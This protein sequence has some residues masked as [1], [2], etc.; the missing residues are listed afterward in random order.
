MYWSGPGRAGSCLETGSVSVQMYIR[1]HAR[2]YVLYIR[3]YLYIIAVPF[4]GSRAR[5]LAP[6]RW[7]PATKE[8]FDLFQCQ[9]SLFFVSKMPCVAVQRSFWVVFGCLRGVLG[10]SKTW[11]PYGTS[12]KNHVFKVLASKI[13][14]G[15]TFQALWEGL[16]VFPEPFLET[17]FGSMG[18]SDGGPCQ[19]TSFFFSPGQVVAQFLAFK[20]LLGCL[21]VRFWVHFWLF[22]G[23]LLHVYCLS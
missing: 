20:S 23:K 14:D 2:I 13:P 8:I 10:P 5:N 15:S 11:I 7:L 12:F 6:P 22:G 4:P 18:Q 17:F 16:R 21:P 19:Q 1:I 9:R 3:V